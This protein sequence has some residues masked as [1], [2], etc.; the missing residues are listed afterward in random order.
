MSNDLLDWKELEQ[1]AQEELQAVNAPGAAIAVISREKILFTKGLGISHSETGVPV[2]PEMLFRIGSV[3]KM[4]TAYTLISLV[5]EHHLD[6]HAPIG[7]SVPDL[8]PQ[9]ARLTIHQILS[10]TAGLKDDFSHYGPHLPPFVLAFHLSANE[11]E[12]Y[13]GCALRAHKRVSV[14]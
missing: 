1:I 6:V 14:G 13:L 7:L 8:P 2:S 4:I 3:T 10:H 11:Q 9:I 5:Q 12:D